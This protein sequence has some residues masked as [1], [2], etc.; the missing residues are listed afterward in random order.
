MNIPIELLTCIA[1]ELDSSDLSNFRLANQRFAHASISLIPRHGIS[2]INISRDI[3][4]LQYILQRHAIAN[5]VKVLRIFHAEWPICSRY[6]W[7]SHNLL[8]G[9]NVRFR[10]SQHFPTSESARRLY[11]KAFTEYRKLMKEQQCRRYSEVIEALHEILVMLPNL[12]TIQVSDMHEYLWRP[13]ANRRYHKLQR[14]IWISPFYSKNITSTVEAV[15]LASGCGMSNLGQVNTLFIS[16]G[17]DPAE[18]Y[19]PR[20]IN[21]YSHI[22]HLT[23]HDFRVCG[24]EEPIRNFLRGF[25][26]LRGLSV[27]FQGWSPSIDAFKSLHWPQLEQLNIRGVWTSE[28][29]FASILERHLPSL[30][31]FSLH[32]P[33]LTEGS[34][35]SLFAKIRA[36]NTRAKIELSGELYGRTRGETLNMECNQTRSHIEDFLRDRESVW[37]FEVA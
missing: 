17:F 36:L 2:V 29:E 3:K 8:F 37:P 21:P 13:K 20:T 28:S 5:N 12:T 4:E 7:E 18:L 14:S 35:Q 31:L 23:I 33:A 9:G 6:E 30:N 10:N 22:Q 34:W 15:L 11:K 1:S 16:G 27:S 25:S 24:N 32:N 19:I 26:A